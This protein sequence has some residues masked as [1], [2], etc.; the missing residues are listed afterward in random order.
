M[1]DARRAPEGVDTSKPNSARVY[2]Y[3]LGGKDN[4]EVDRQV[5]NRM[6]LVAPDTR[7]T[8]WFSR[9]FL[10]QAVQTAAAAG[11]RQ[12]I[13]LGAG[14]PT[15][16]AVHEV[17][18]KIDAD[19]RIAA[20]DYDPV[21]YAHSNALLAGIPGVT[22][23]LADIRDIDELIGRLRSE[24]AVDFDRPVAVM[25]CGVL[26][27]IMDDERPDE[28]IA[29][30]A[31]VMAPGSYLAL[32]QGSTDSTEAFT[33]QARRDLTDSPSRFVFRSAAQTAAL[34]DGFEILAPGIVPLQNWLDGELP[35]TDLVI[36]GGICRKP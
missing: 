3:L 13:D 18:Q 28:I 19:A 11:V 16:P 26:H 8:A 33:S 34:L 21:V 5:A 1:S 23:I 27:F 14:I 22:P 7:I 4:Y 30:L 17:A 20:V 6:L 35:A 10:I 24:A 25:L 12:F 31:E 9:Q 32:T 15:T 2:D 36:F 29:R